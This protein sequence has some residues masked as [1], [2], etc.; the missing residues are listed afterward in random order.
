[1]IDS[2]IKRPTLSIITV[3]LNEPLLQRTCE[4]IV[5]QTFQNFEWI[6]IDG[7]S[8]YETL[9]IFERYKSRMDYFI[10][11]PDGGIYFGMNKGIFQS[12]GKWLNFMNAGDYLVHDSV[13]RD[14]FNF[15]EENPDG[16]LIY[17]DYIIRNERGS[18]V[19]KS[20]EE[21]NKDCLFYTMPHHE[22]S[23]IKR[24]FFD[25]YGYY[26]T[27]YLLMADRDFYIKLV[28]GNQCKFNRIDMPIL[29]YSQAGRS[30]KNNT[31]IFR[32][33]SRIR[34]VYFSQE[35]S[36]RL[37]RKQAQQVRSMLQHKGKTS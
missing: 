23:F 5:N 26:D 20:P 24:I 37:K 18:R 21:I 1:M 4:S 12:K 9:E 34:S 33:L 14:I 31:Q 27:T 15:I 25:M 16:D 32:E 29:V 30:S 22:A 6:V 11:E 28:V 17:G 35:E 13:L 7:G 3:C 8:N 10:S 36:L 19:I 2:C